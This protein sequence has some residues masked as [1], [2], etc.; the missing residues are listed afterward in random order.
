[1]DPNRKY[2]LKAYKQL[3]DLNDYPGV[4]PPWGNLVAV[5][6]N[7][8]EIKW[9]ITLGEY[10]EL[11]KKGIAPTGTQL[12]GGGIVTAGGVLFIGA[13]RDEKFRAFDKNSGELL[14][15]YQLPAGGYATPST[16]SLNGQQYVVIAAGGGGFQGTKLGDKYLAFKLP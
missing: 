16:Y 2:R 3:R 15:E 4:K 13:S 8:G 12:F 10:S 11:T 6:L 1:M 14:W 7:A 9:K 5:D